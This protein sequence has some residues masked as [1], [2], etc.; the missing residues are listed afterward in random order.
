MLA[1]AKKKIGNPIRRA[2][3]WNPVTIRGAFCPA[4]RLSIWI[5]LQQTELRIFW[6]MLIV[7]TYRIDFGFVGLFVVDQ[8]R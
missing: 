1:Q 5:G 2:A 7:T 4:A 8:L 6:T 3:E